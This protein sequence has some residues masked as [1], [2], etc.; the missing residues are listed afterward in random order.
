MQSCPLTKLA[1]DDLH[2]VDDNFVTWL[3]GVA[4][5]YLV[6]RYGSGLPEYEV[7]QW[8]M[9]VRGVA[10]GYLAV[11][12]GRGLPWVRGVAMGYLAMRLSLIHI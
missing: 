12:C 3:Q 9:W 2:S 7:W 10:M 11:R 4:M 6:K 8:V 1:D 5:G